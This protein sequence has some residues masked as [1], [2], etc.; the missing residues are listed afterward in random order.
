THTAPFPFNNAY[1]CLAT[2]HEM[3]AYG[4]HVGEVLDGLVWDGLTD[5]TN[6]L[7]AVR[8]VSTWKQAARAYWGRW[9]QSQKIACYAHGKIWHLPNV[10]LNIPWAHEIIA[11]VR[12]K[13]WEA[14]R[15]ALHVYIDS[16]ITPHKLRTGDAIGDWRL[17]KT[18][19]GIFVRGTGQYG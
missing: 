3:E 5:P 4:L 16:V 10:A 2:P 19:N 14:S 9:G 13:L 1:E 15:D 6:M 8:L 7:A 11:R 17:E 12:M 18:Y